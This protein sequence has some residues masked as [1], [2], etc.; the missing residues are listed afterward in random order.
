MWIGGRRCRSIK[1]TAAGE[2]KCVTELPAYA[3]WA[4]CA[5][6][7]V[8]S[9]GREGG[10]AQ[11]VRTRQQAQPRSQH[12]SSGQTGSGG[13][14]S[15]QRPAGTTEDTCLKGI[16]RK[17]TEAAVWMWQIALIA[18][19]WVPLPGAPAGGPRRSRRPAGAQGTRRRQTAWGGAAPAFCVSSWFRRCLF[20]WARRPALT[21]TW[22]GGYSGSICQ[23]TRARRAARDQRA[24]QRHVMW[25]GRWAPRRS[26]A[27]GA[28][29]APGS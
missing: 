16:Q 8:K 20:L 15:S 10:L 2:S 25:L 29:A 14:P 3:R 17:K 5:A 6:A 18:L 26:G 21:A 19:I 23:P 9:R 12:K 4:A 1:L 28:W 27:R 13:V 11:R 24:P 22:A 7:T